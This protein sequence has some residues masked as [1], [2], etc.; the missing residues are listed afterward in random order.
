MCCVC[1]DPTLTS[2]PRSC[3][4]QLHW[5]GGTINQDTCTQTLLAPP[6]L[7]TQPDVPLEGHK[8][9][10]SFQ[11]AVDDPLAV[12]EVESLQHLAAY[13]LNLGLCEASIQL[14]KRGTLSSLTTLEG[15]APDH[16]LV[17][18]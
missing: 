17:D 10:A 3:P 15:P 9:V 8:H 5:P 12:Q 1:E 2:R 13:D 16:F 7:L 6:A 14:W 11:V 18:A 4:L